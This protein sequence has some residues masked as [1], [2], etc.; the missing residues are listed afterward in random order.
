MLRKDGVLLNWRFGKTLP[1]FICKRK[2]GV[3]S[4]KRRMI[5]KT[6]TDK[7]MDFN[8]CKEV[9]VNI[10]CLNRCYAKS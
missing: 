1:F 6:I 4:L 3:L 10:I 9:C 2:M 8:M 7:T 5:V